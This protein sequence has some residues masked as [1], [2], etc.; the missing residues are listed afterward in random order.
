MR[1][2]ATPATKSP[3]LN[4]PATNSSLTQALQAFMDGTA[5]LLEIPL[6]ILAGWFG[7]RIPLLPLIRIGAGAAVV[8]TSASGRSQ[9]CVAVV[10]PVTVQRRVY[11]LY[12]W[13]WHDLVSKPIAGASGP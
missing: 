12:C 1:L 9:R 8:C 6:M 7:G 11:R 2:A 10:C 13:P 4:D 5:A 3:C